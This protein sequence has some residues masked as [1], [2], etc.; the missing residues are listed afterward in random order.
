MTETNT[1]SKLLSRPKLLVYGVTVVLLVLF[2]QWSKGQVI[3]YLSGGRVVTVL[4]RLLQFRYMENTGA[5]FSVLTGRTLFLSVAT[6]LIL[7]VAVLLLVFQKVPKT[8]DQVAIVLLVAGGAGNL[9]DRVAR[10]YVVDFIEVLFT[11]FAVFNFADCCVT[12]G[13]A[14]LILSTV[15]AFV[16]DSGDA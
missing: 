2:D 14:I 7:A 9:I 12:V 10:H 4:P 13:A 6:A 5:A 16:K 15:L 1:S 8:L 11:N 3:Q